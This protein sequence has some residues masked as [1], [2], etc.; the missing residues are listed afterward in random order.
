MA[1]VV[2]LG[3]CGDDATTVPDP[4][5]TVPSSTTTPGSTT[6]TTT[7][8]APGSTTTTTNPCP[9]DG[10][11]ADA[12]ATVAPDATDSVTATTAGDD[13]ASTAAAVSESSI[14]P[15]TTST[16]I[17]E[18]DPR[19][20]RFEFR[21]SIGVFPAAGEFCVPAVGSVTLTVPEGTTVDFSEVTGDPTA[22]AG[23]QSFELEITFDPGLPT[24]GQMIYSITAGDVRFDGSGT[25]TIEWS[26]FGETA[27]TMRLADDAATATAGP[28]V[29]DDTQQEAG[30]FDVREVGTC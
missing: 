27:G 19:G 10:T 13:S 4:C 12:V 21:G 23:E 17:P 22:P 15:T 1:G 14:D 20:R 7:T 18:A 26:D 8:T 16:T 11:D 25:Y 2:V 24:T 30:I 6:T 29:V 3:A 28:F 5:A 9:P